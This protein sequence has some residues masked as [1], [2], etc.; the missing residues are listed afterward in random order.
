MFTTLL[1]IH[2]LAIAGVNFAEIRTD[3]MT[4]APNTIQI[5]VGWDE[6]PVEVSLLIHSAHHVP[7]AKSAPVVLYYL[8]SEQQQRK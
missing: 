1:S 2:V 7:T 4:H 6:S 8:H 3:A 5:T